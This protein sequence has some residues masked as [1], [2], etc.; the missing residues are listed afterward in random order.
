MNTENLKELGKN[1]W[2]IPDDGSEPYMVVQGKTMLRSEMI[3]T[4]IR[5]G[6]REELAVEEVD[7]GRYEEAVYEQNYRLAENPIG[8]CQQAYLDHYGEGCL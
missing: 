2:V 1:T 8:A 6:F 7:N 3:H 4:L 5:G